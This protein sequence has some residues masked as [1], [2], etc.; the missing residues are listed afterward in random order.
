[1][2]T[3]DDLALLALALPEVSANELAGGRPEYAVAGKVFCRHREPRRDALDEAGERMTDVLM[4]RLPE[5][6]LKE[7]YLAD[8]RGV[9]F[10][11][12]HFAGYPAILLRIPGLALLTR[13]ELADLLE[14]A[15]LAVAPKRLAKVR[16]APTP[17]DQFSPP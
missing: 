3:M 13:E 17:T 5:V 2:A 11:T 6:E 4:V 8:A 14:D 12:P 15:W 1:M 16:P 10:T 7:A 9:Y